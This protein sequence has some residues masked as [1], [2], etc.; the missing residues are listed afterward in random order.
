MTAAPVHFY[1]Y[2]RV[3][4]ARAAAAR[5]TVA[6]MLRD[7]EQRFGVVG[8]LL[9][10]EKDP[11]LWMEVYEQVRE[12]DRFETLLGELCASS[13]LISFLAPGATRRVERF[14]AA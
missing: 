9:R 4:P 10:G 8:R 11:A 3:D 6:G 14:V 2:Y 13:G 5:A 12:P 7:I 1:C